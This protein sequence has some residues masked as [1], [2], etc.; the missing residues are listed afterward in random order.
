LDARKVHR[1]LLTTLIGDTPKSILCFYLYIFKT[2]TQFQAAPLYLFILIPLFQ[3]A[4]P[5]QIIPGLL[6]SIMSEGSGVWMHD[7]ND[8]LM[9]NGGPAVAIL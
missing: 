4:V 7:M 8:L 6:I 1:L 5:L 9:I 3:R 2:F